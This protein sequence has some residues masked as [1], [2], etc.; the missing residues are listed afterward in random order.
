VTLLKPTILRFD[1]VDSTN[2]EGMRQARAGA[3]EGLCIVAR[4]Q[5]AGR[6]RLDRSWQ[7]PKDAGLYF[8]TVLRPRLKMNAWPLITLMAALAVSDTLRHLHGLS[9][10]I[11][12]PNDVCLGDRKLSGIL[13]ET[14]ETEAG[15]ACV[16]GIGINLRKAGFPP[17]LEALATSIEGATHLVADAEE[18]LQTLLRHLAIRYERLQETDGAPSLLNDWMAASSYA[19][20]KNVRVEAGTEVFAGVTRGLEDDGALRVK[21]ASGEIKVVRAG[22]VRSVRSKGQAER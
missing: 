12:W 14:F 22:D 5:T 10:D 4:E 6:G 16:L 20:G 11:K 19:F 8:S 3:Q 17:E 7:S 1:S 21:V 15:S 2:L 18:L 13:A 9:T